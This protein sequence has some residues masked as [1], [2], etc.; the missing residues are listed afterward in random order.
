MCYLEHRVVRESFCKVR[1]CTIEHDACEMCGYV[2]GYNVDF[3]IGLS[4]LLLPFEDSQHYLDLGDR[5]TFAM[6]KSDC[7]C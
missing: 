5:V 2:D 3:K 7:K 1:A 6:P 4:Y